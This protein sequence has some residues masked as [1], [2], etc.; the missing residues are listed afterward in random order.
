[1]NGKSSAGCSDL[2]IVN[3]IKNTTLETMTLKIYNGKEK[4]EKG[5]IQKRIGLPK[6]K[7]TPDILLCRQTY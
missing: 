1:M 4:G 7:R 3:S 5:L 2:V 6:L